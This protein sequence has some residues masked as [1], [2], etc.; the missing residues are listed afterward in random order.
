[1]LALSLHVVVKPR[2]TAKTSKIVESRL[3]G[4]PKVDSMAQTDILRGRGTPRNPSFSKCRFHFFA[5]LNP[6]LGNC[7]KQTYHTFFRF[8][9][10][11]RKSK[12]I[13]IHDHTSWVIA[14]CIHH[15]IWHALRHNHPYIYANN[16]QVAGPCIVRPGTSLA[17]SI[18]VESTLTCFCVEI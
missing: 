11:A 7:P 1:M 8:D 17:H 18:K 12:N 3:V 13:S 2:K 16:M 5:P 4:S 15:Q 6:R 14:S 9:M 10:S